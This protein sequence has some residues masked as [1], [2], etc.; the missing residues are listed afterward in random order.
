MLI[1]I[2]DSFLTILKFYLIIGTLF[3]IYFVLFGVSQL[4]KNAKNT[5]WHFRLIIMPGSIFLWFILLYKLMV[6][7]DKK[8]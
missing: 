1:T 3:S 4:D 5:A 2:I 8:S 7:H 6:N